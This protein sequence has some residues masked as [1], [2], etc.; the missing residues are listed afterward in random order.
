MTEHTETLQQKLPLSPVGQ[1]LESFAYII[2]H[3]VRS[4]VRALM[5]IPLWIEEDL[6]ASGH[7]IDPTTKTNL[8]LLNDHARRLDRML[9]DVL[10]YSRIGRMQEN[11]PVDLHAAVETVLSQI[12]VPKAFQV[13]QD[14]RVPTL[15][16]G[17][18]DALTLLGALVSN[19][20]QHHAGSPGKITISSRPDGDTVCLEV[21]DNG[22]GIPADK[23]ETVFEVMRKLMPRDET[24]GSGMG[25][26]IV[27]K[28]ARIH[29]GTAQISDT[30]NG[31]GCRVVV[32]LP[33]THFVN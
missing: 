27:Q 32:R 1:D 9:V 19:A 5:E 31:V 13:V 33:Q 14:L 3:D 15:L 6:A 25:L 2:S 22:P 23:R 26:A 12:G 11:R 16:I 18:R 29:G 4:S 28:I 30:E 17:E 20:I 21:S 10:I 7:D 24:E 8:R